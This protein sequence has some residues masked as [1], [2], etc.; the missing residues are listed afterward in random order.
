MESDKNPFPK[1]ELGLLPR[2]CRVFHFIFDHLQNAGMSDHNS[3]GGPALDRALY[4][5]HEQLELDY[6]T[7]PE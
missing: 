2:T 4:D 1:F 5:G 6:G 7:L 3:G